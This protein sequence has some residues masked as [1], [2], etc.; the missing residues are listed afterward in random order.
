MCRLDRRLQSWGFWDFLN[1]SRGG[2]VE[3]NCWLG[4]DFQG[5]LYIWDSLLLGFVYS[6]LMNWEVCL[7]S[8]LGLSWPCFDVCRKKFWVVLLGTGMQ[9]CRGVYFVQF[10]C[11]VL[12]GFAPLWRFVRRDQ[13]WSYVWRF[14]EPLFAILST[15]FFSVVLGSEL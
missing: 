12:Q 7:N 11:E 10:L 4:I 5:I 13:S 1:A 14:M 9:R 15:W 8:F 2:L 3:E 6:F